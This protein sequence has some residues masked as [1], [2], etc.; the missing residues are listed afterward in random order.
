MVSII[1]PTYEAH[2]RGVEFI[3]DL[4]ESIGEQTYLDYEIIISDNSKDREIEKFVS[5]QYLVTYVRNKHKD[6]PASNFNNA[7]NHAKGSIIKPMC[8]DDRFSSP[9]DLAEFAKCERWVVSR[10]SDHKP[11]LQEDLKKLAEGENTYGAPSAVAWKANELRF[12]ENLLWLMDCDMWVQLSLKYG[13]PTLIKAT[14]N[15]RK[16]EGQL[17]YTMANG[18]RRVEDLN[19]IQKKYHGI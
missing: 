9:H 7:I 11:S 19:Y 8:Q 17:T 13:F 16:W 15:I 1:I 18:S 5:N 4:L 2:G 10:S 14:V 6:N 12:D 3:R